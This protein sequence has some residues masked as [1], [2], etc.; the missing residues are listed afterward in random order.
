MP[1]S[2]SH[3]SIEPLPLITAEANGTRDGYDAP[4]ILLTDTDRRTYAAR[5]AL[6]L[7]D[8]G[9]EVSAIC[10]TDGH[11]LLKTRVVRRIFT[12]SGFR[13]LAALQR[14]M[15]EA[16][17]DLVVPCDDRGVRHM[18][19]LYAVA[20]WPGTADHAIA[21]SIRRS[22]G[23]PASYSI[24]SARYG[25]LKIASE[26]GLPVPSTHPVHTQEEF[27]TLESELAFPWVLK[28]DE[29]WGGRGVRI[30]HSSQAAKQY[31]LDVSR[32]FRLRRA[33]KRMIV[34]RDPFWLQ[35]W[36]QGRKPAV[37]AQAYVQGRPANCAVF[38]WEGEILAGIAVE[39]VTSHGATGPASI[40]H[41]LEGSQMM[42]C[43]ERL[44]RRLGLSGFFGLDFIVE[45]GTGDTYLIEMNPR[46]TPLCH[47]RLGKGRDMIGALWAQL[48][49]QPCP[50]KP[51]VTDKDLIAYFPQAGNSNG[52]ILEK[53]YQDV[54]SA[55]DELIHELL[56][57]WPERSLL[58]RL[59]QRLQPKGGALH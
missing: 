33:I 44:A 14:A 46:T 10:S 56:R 11:P 39:V 20:T 48:S 38:C 52:E 43:A 45:D 16:Q 12:Y 1:A 24:V 55:G 3:T 35:P 37:I 57:P 23:P 53:A 41:V 47:L 32:P 5:L 30:A 59:T 51:A 7:A 50:E 15:A 54:P 2:Q 28:A 34:N 31:F 36:W 21:E 29:T 8:A 9:C 6:A 40:V 49:G 4:K 42:H 17:P 13:P 26:E 27:G 19:E 58:F 25:L 18:H 22:L